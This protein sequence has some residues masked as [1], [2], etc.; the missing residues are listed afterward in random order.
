MTFEDLQRAHD[1]EADEDYEHKEL[2]RCEYCGS[3]VV[4]NTCKACAN[5]EEVG[6]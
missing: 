1:N 2:D 4:G 3:I 6:W 5:L